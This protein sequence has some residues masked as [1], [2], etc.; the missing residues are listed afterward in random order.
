MTEIQTLNLVNYYIDELHGN[1]RKWKSFEY[2]ETYLANLVNLISADFSQLEPLCAPT[3]QSSSPLD[4]SVSLWSLC[5][6]Q[7]FSHHDKKRPA[8]LARK[9]SNCTYNLEKNDLE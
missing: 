6:F 7:T 1:D 2:G 4:S 5:S 3:A 8:V 9:G